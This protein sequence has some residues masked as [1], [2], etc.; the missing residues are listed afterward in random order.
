MALAL[1]QSEGELDYLQATQPS[2]TTLGSLLGHF[3]TDAEG[4]TTY[5]V[6]STD[7]RRLAL[8]GG[9]AT[10]QLMDAAIASASI[11]GW[12]TLGAIQKHAIQVRATLQSVDQGF[13]NP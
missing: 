8:V 11:L 2:H 3:E 12:K 6:E 1:G 7:L 4:T 13:D 10:I 5:L 9:R